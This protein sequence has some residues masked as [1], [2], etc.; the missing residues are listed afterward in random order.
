MQKVVYRKPVPDRFICNYSRARGVLVACSTMK[1]VALEIT[2]EELPQQAVEA[3]KAMLNR[4]LSLS[5]SST[6]QSH[7]ERRKEGANL[8]WRL[9]Y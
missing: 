5:R 8:Q 6:T 9:T 1:E 4:V 2:P 3:R 7:P